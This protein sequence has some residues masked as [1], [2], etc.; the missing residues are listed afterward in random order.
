MK[1]IVNQLPRI[2]AIF[3]LVF[4]LLPMLY[5]QWGNVLNILRNQ[6]NIGAAIA[7][8]GVVTLLF[9]IFFAKNIN[10]KLVWFFLAGILFLNLGVRF[11]LVA[12]FSTNLFSDMLDV[13]LFAQ[14]IISGE[15]FRNL[16]SYTYIPFSTYLNM[17]AMLLSV[18]YRFL[19]PAEASAKL[20]MTLL[21]TLSALLTFLW[22]WK[23]LDDWRAGFVAALWFA[24]MPVF[25]AYTGVAT[26]DFVSMVFIVLVL[27]WASESPSDAGWLSSILLG[28]FIALADWF[29][30]MGIVL[31]LSYVLTQLIFWKEW[32]ADSDKTVTLKRLVD[33]GLRLV[34]T[35][36]VF[37][38]L[39]GVP[40][41]L[42]GILLNGVNIPLS[43]QRMGANLY[44]GLNQ[45]TY[46]LH[47]S[48]DG[49]IIKNTYARYGDD[50]NGANAEL[51]HMAFARAQNQD[52][53]SLFKAKFLRVW[54]DS[55]QQISMVMHGSAAKQLMNLVTP[56]DALMYF[57]LTVFMLFG[58]ILG[59]LNKVERHFVFM[60]LFVFLFAALLLI[61][62]AQNRYRVIVYPYLFLL[63]SL[64]M[65]R[66]ACFLQGKLPHKDWAA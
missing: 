57:L 62:E 3:I 19:S 51:M 7:L 14:D 32:L 18:V 29:R 10:S 58:A 53:F 38:I 61:V 55:D 63:A 15:P 42:T 52:V 37:F 28:V 54:Q 13:H 30:P 34:V 43:S 5:A 23:K 6:S 31:V 48:E 39:S 25:V 16:G 36:A 17:T 2:F 24:T 66:M 4:P 9:G 49:A 47:S 40:Q 20:M 26:S 22:A 33:P 46:G 50:F 35:I 11:F 27:F 1:K 45:E 60:W 21:A 44:I 59:I 8:L 41:M 64:G 12:A 56:L 65:Q